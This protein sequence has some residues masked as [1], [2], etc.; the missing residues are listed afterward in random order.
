[1]TAVSYLTHTQASPG[2]TPLVSAEDD[3]RI[4]HFLYYESRLL[5]DR[6]FSEWVELFAEGATYEVPVRVNREEGAD[7]FSRSKAFDDNKATLTI[8]VE[9]LSTEFAWAEQPPSR[10]RHYIGNVMIA[11]AAEAREFEV[12]S[13]EL[14]YRSRGYATE[15][16]LFSV[17]RADVLRDEAE[18]LRIVSRVVLMDQTTI[19]AHNL[20]LFF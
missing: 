6:R 7:A 20:S 9:R 4:R 18:G 1:M 3:H 8:R 5:D 12:V 16:D 11:P 2:P 19:G 13:N 17:Q 15:Y 14:V 10:V